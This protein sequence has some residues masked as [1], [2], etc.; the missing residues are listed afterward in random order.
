MA[1]IQLGALVSDIR[2]SIAG[3]TFQRSASGLTCRKKPIQ[4]KSGSN[5]QQI[6][7]VNTQI[8]AE[9]SILL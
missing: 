2:W 7:G 6:R 8:V 3:N 4:R 9:R 1:I 5:S